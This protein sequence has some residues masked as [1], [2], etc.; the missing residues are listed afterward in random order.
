MYLI[1]SDWKY[2]L[3]TETYEKSLLRTFCYNNKNL[4]KA[5]DFRKL[6]N[7][8]IYFT[9]PSNSTKYSKLF[10]FISCPNVFEGHHPHFIFNCLYPKIL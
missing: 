1:S 9:H 10:K 7:K 4:R 2:L 8:E 5:K 6:S 3:R